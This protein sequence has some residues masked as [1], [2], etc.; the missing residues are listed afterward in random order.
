MLAYVGHMLAHVEPSWATHYAPCRWPQRLALVLLV[1]MIIYGSSF[2]LTCFEVCLRELIYGYLWASPACLRSCLHTKRLCLTPVTAPWSH[3]SRII[4][5]MH[6]VTTVK[7]DFL[8]WLETSS[9]P[10]LYLLFC[11]ASF[12]LATSCSW[13]SSGTARVQGPEK[14]DIPSQAHM[15]GDNG[16]QKGETRRREGGRAIQHRH[17]CGD[18]RPSRRDVFQWLCRA[19][20]WD[21]STI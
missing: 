14:A 9:K 12:Q 1:D 17:T 10:C 20:A 19:K 8:K 5:L 7:R 18:T 6:Q 4:F 15:W 2:F 13:L 16:R 11:P 21:I 3:G